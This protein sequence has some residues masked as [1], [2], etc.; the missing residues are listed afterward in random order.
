MR[1]LAVDQARNGAWS[2]FETTT[3]E[4]VGYGTFSFDK[5]KFEYS[6]VVLCISE[7]LSAV[8]DTYDVSAVF[9]EDIQLRKNALSFKR[10]A[11]L[12]GVLIDMC[13]RRKLL[14]WLISPTQWQSHC[15]T[16]NTF[17]NDA[18]ENAKGNKTKVLSVQFVK[19]K[20]GIETKNDNLA[21]AI[22]IGNYAIENF[23]R[24]CSME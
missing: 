23:Q 10:L 6:R 17:A 24:L 7:I 12:Q 19:S 21:D 15:R 13:E 16:T 2:V 18:Y 4:L 20:F 14:Y 5:K 22:C 1:C 11:Q 8:I 3:G 9:L